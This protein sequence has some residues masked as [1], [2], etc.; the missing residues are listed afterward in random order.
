MIRENIKV[1]V[2]NGKIVETK[3]KKGFDLEF[4]GV[5]YCYYGRIRNI[6]YNGKKYNCFPIMYIHKDLSKVEDIE[7]FG[8]EGGRENTFEDGVLWEVPV[9]YDIWTN[10]RQFRDI[11]A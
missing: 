3:S 1:R 6:E 2:S 4:D 7:L 9:N 8:C 5:Y 10:L 11:M